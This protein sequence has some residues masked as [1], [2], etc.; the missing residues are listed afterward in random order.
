MHLTTIFLFS[1]RVYTLFTNESM[2]VFKISDLTVF[3]I[4]AALMV[5]D[6]ILMIVY[7]VVANPRLELIVVDPYRPS[8]NYYNCVSN[9]SGATILWVIFG[10]HMATFVVG[11]Y[12][13]W[14][15][16]L[17]PFK[18]YDESKSIAFSIYNVGFFGIILAVILNVAQATHY[19]LFGL[20]CF[21]CVAGSL[22]TINILFGSKMYW[23]TNGFSSTSSGSSRT[24]S[25]GRSLH[26]S[27]HTMSSAQTRERDANRLENAN[28]RIEKLEKRVK[29]LK[30]TIK[31]YQAREQEEEEEEVNGQE[32]E[33]EKGEE[34]E[35]SDE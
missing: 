18:I 25:G 11:A 8:L 12:L 29:K 7:Q 5:P 26:L 30:R 10:L 35:G 22:I 16:R 27:T 3:G 32:S 21:L 23:V 28:K 6:I 19:V 13:A 31:D 24:T 4:V 15:V 17:I 20:L 9:S 2:T 34:E 33:N 1:R 14:Q